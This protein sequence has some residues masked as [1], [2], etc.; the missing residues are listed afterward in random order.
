MNKKE[1]KCKACG[2]VFTTTWSD[3]ESKEE[4]KELWGDLP[5]EEQVIVCDDCFK[6]MGL[7]KLL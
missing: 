2:K 1:Y 3:E 4:M 5:Q 6:E 7:D